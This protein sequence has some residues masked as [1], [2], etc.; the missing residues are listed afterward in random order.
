[1]IV[2]KNML[3]K[4]TIKDY[5][6]RIYS[7]KLL[8]LINDSW[9]DI[10]QLIYET[11]GEFKD[12][13]THFKACKKALENGE[14]EL[15]GFEQDY[16]QSSN[17]VSK[18]ELKELIF[19]YKKERIKLS[20]ERSQIRAY[21]RRISREETL[22]EIALEAAREIGKT[23]SL[24]PANLQPIDRAGYNEAIVQ[25]SDWHYG[26]EIDSAWN[27]FNPKICR[28]R[29]LT[30]LDEL[31]AFC[32][33]YGVNNLHIVNLGDLIAGRIHNTIRLESRCDVITQTMMVS[34]ILAEFISSLTAEGINVNYYDCID[35]HSRLEPIKTQSLELESLTRI[36]TWYLETRLES[37]K[38]FKIHYS[39]FGDDIL[40]FTVLNGKYTVGGVHG[41]KDRPI[42][43]VDNLTMMT[44]LNYD[45]IL[46]AHLHHFS[47]EEKNEV[48]VIS[49]GSLMGTDT[50]AKDLRLTSKPS[51]NI[52]LVN[53]QSVCDYIHRVVLN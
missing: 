9:A 46:T 50:F 25:L 31:I 36:V 11:T 16:E 23:K 37:N 29:I 18:E 10:A 12:R 24:L 44:R 32:Y 2:E 43:V 35:N 14:L 7:Y 34:E 8:G 22:K 33:T 27:T 48:V 45:L 49:N 4:E 47:C 42:K 19:E 1:M 21:E 30:L 3:P 40:T 28:E 52:I 51:Q 20:D 39:E 5:S 38:L 26:I 13:S 15:E 53:E 41:H 6:L 17:E